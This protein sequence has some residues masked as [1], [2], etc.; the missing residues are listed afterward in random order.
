M[1]V[2]FLNSPEDTLVP[3]H[4]VRKLC[5]EV[6][7]IPRKLPLPLCLFLTEGT[8]AVSLVRNMEIVPRF[9]LMPAWRSP[10]KLCPSPAL[11]HTQA[12][13][14]HSREGSAELRQQALA[15]IGVVILSALDLIQKGTSKLSPS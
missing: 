2:I 15:A 14:S 4:S 6:T 8:Q 11:P 13:S 5:E 3:I 12:A 10:Q 1:D 9:L 7:A